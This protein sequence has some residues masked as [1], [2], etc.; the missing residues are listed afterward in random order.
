MSKVGQITEKTITPV[1]Y[2]DFFTDFS[3]H[4]V[5]GQLNKKT[6]ENAVKQSVRNLLLTNKYERLFQP[7]IGSNLTSMLFENAM[8]ETRVMLE[9]YVEDVL[10]NYEP[11]AEF[12]SA[13]ADVNGDRNTMNVTVRFRIINTGE[14]VTLAVVLERNR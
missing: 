6:N 7:D 8:P 10:V 5:T 14:E 1:V 11:R 13:V 12:I 4:A 3:R 2:S 9:E